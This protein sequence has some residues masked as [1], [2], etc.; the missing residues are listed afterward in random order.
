ME[1]LIYR[2]DGQWFDLDPSDF[3]KVFH[4]NSFTSRRT[5][6]NGEYCLEVE[7][8][9]VVISYEMPG[10]QVVFDGD[11]SR[12]IAKQIVTEICQN[13]T[14]FTGQSGEVLDFT[15][16]FKGKIIRFYR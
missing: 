11:I 3:E 4:P 9:Q 12:E 15:G 14:S 6:G 13:V 2:T 8:C 7:G 1:F 16:E 10:L 5:E